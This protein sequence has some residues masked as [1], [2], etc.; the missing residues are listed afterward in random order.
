MFQ[1]DA[2]LVGWVLPSVPIRRWV[3][4][5]RERI[6]DPQAREAGH[7]AIRGQELEHAVLDAEREM[8][9]S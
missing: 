1:T 8:F 7:V 9:A 3:L 6:S 2:Y 5:L 4:R